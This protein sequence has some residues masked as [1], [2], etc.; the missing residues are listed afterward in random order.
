MPLIIIIIIII[1]IVISFDCM[2]SFPFHN[3]FTFI[4][5][6]SENEFRKNFHQ[7]SNHC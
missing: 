5:K 3:I 2:L 1:M 7:I 6:F 4:L